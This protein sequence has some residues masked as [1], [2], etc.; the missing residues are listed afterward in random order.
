[1][2]E[3]ESSFSEINTTNKNTRKKKKQLE[4]EENEK[5]KQISERMNNILSNNY[6]GLTESANISSETEVD[7]M[8]RKNMMI[9][10]RIIAV[11]IVLK[12]YPQLE[13]DR[14]HIIDKILYTTEQKIE[15]YVLEKIT[16]GQF[17]F[18]KDANGYLIDSDINV[19]GVTVTENDTDKYV[20]F[21]SMNNFHEVKNKGMKLMENIDE[22]FKL[23]PSDIFIKTNK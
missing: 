16:I 21:D 18:Y 9:Q 17:S 10:E 14:K 4:E 5:I 6:E 12:L 23:K 8:F 22:I 1:M 19:V 2:S 3:I 15:L 13:K 20:L 7:K 11:D